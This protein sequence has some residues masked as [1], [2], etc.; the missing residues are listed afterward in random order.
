MIPRESRYQR[1]PQCKRCG[2]D[3]FPGDKCAAKGATCF[4]CNRKGQFS[5]Q[6]LSKTVAATSDQLNL[7]TAFLGV[8]DS[9]NTSSW[10]VKLQLQGTETQFKMDTGAEVMAISEQTFNNL[11]GVTLTKPSKILHGPTGRTLK[12][13]GQ[14]SGTISIDNEQVSEP[15]YVI[16]GLRTNLLGL[17]VIAALNLISR[18]NATSTSILRNPIGQH[19]THLS[20]KVWETWG[21]HT[22]LSCERML[23][24]MPCTLHG[25]YPHP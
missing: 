12:V 2:K 19:S 25:E 15:I 10:T 22:P 7:D 23:S 8:L 16:R 24:H 21:S 14:F 5:S 17:P 6:C 11:R 18:I 3:H 20:S 1:K 13:L 4:K 9:G